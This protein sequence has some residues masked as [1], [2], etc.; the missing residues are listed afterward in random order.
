RCYSSAWQ[1]PD[2]QHNCLTKPRL[3]PP[4]DNP[5]LVHQLTWIGAEAASPRPLA[6]ISEPPLASMVA[7]LER[8]RGYGDVLMAGTGFSSP[9][10]L[11]LFRPQILPV[12]IAQ[13]LPDLADLTGALQPLSAIHH[14]HFAVDVRAPVA[15]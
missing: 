3:L 8:G 10:R 1:K 11:S 9:P 13:R 4:A 15:H 14:D 5:T 2:A 6:F 7:P 12:G